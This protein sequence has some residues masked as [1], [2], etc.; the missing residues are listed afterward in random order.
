MAYIKGDHGPSIRRPVPVSRK[1]PAIHKSI[2]SLIGAMRGAKPLPNYVPR[3]M[4]PGIFDKIGSKQIPMRPFNLPG[5]R[6]KSHFDPGIPT[7]DT[8]GPHKPPFN[9]G[10]DI[11][12]MPAPFP[13]GPVSGYGAQ[14]EGWAAQVAGGGPDPYSNPPDG[15]FPPMPQPQPVDMGSYSPPQHPYDFGGRPSPPPF[16]GGAFGGARKPWEGKLN[17]QALQALM[18]SLR[19]P[20]QHRFF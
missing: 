15:P 11:M 12:P 7:Q 13:P 6:K 5:I 18:G 14:G 9:M 2:A 8:F 4:P 19:Q 10:G 17:L 3:P 16:M 1:N 20:P